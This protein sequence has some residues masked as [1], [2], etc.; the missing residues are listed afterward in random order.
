MDSVENNAEYISQQWGGIAK[1]PNESQ[2]NSLKTPKGISISEIL[3][4]TWKE[5]PI[6]LDDD[7][8]YIKQQQESALTNPNHY[9][10][11]NLW[12]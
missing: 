8:R 2:R 1:Y 9:K 7:N 5:S 4:E 10:K 11:K 3:Q 12:N 6:S